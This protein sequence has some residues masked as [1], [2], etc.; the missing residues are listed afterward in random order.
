MSPLP[1]ASFHLVT[2]P[3][4]FGSFS[5]RNQLSLS[6]RR[7]RGRSR[8]DLNARVIYQVNQCSYGWIDCG[9]T[10]NHALLGHSIASSLAHK[11]AD[12]GYIRPN[13]G[14]VFQYGN[15]ARIL[16]RA[17]QARIRLK[18]RNLAGL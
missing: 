12:E 18:P 2:V 10:K 8:L 16:R 13:V 6:R 15:P 14:Y 4:I 9:L 7:R 17:T 3:L 11:P 5:L 1:T